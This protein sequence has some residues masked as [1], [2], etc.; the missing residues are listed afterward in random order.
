MGDAADPAGGALP[1]TP[2]DELP[3]ILATGRGVYLL[4]EENA[5]PAD[6]M[7]EVPGVAGVWSGGAIA[8]EYASAA[9]GQQITYCFLDEDPVVA[10]GQL[11]PVLE[12]R[13]ATTVARPMLAAPFCSVVPHEWD[14]YLP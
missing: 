14:R 8:S 12:R 3:A 6:A 11:R 10:A 7:A 13:W 5:V 1:G 9:P 2:L 4:L